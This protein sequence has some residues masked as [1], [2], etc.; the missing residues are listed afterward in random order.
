MEEKE[1][2]EEEEGESEEAL[3]PA[4]PGDKLAHQLGRQ[5]RLDFSLLVGGG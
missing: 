1:K 2:E 5:L 4:S 3:L